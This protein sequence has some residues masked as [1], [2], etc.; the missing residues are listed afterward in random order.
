VDWRLIDFEKHLA[1]QAAEIGGSS[2]QKSPATTNYIREVL[3]RYGALELPDPIR[4]PDDKPVRVFAIRNQAKWLELRANKG[5][6]H[7]ACVEE[8]LVGHPSD[9]YHASYTEGGLPND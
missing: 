6:G 1:Q 2:Y 4:P 8:Y 3:K 7:R 9:K 5:G